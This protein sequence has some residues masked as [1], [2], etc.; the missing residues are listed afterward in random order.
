MGKTF[1]D[2]GSHIG[3]FAVLMSE[4]FDNV[5]AIEPHPNNFKYLKKNIGLNRL[6]NVIPIN[7]AVSNSKKDLFI[8]NLEMNTGAAKIKSQGENKVKCQKLDYLINQHK[9]NLGK[10]SVI[11]IDVEGHELEVLEGGKRALSSSNPTLIIESFNPKSITD[12]LSRYGYHLKST[13]DHYN[14]VFIK[15][16]NI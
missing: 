5:Y 1:I 12:F 10:S 15:S 14:H 4:K 6:K 2:V 3:R 13:L 7:C 11:L 8:D 9:I 16:K